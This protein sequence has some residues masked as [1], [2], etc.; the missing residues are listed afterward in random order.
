MRRS[1][2]V[3]IALLGVYVAA[4]ESCARRECVDQNNVV[5]DDRFCQG[6]SVPDYRWFHTYSSYGGIG[7][8]VDPSSGTVRGV[9]GG[10]GEAASGHG[11]G[12]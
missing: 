9:F 3:G 8:R 2:L 5:V 10:A 12:E 1:H 11:A 7:T 4:L 6:Q